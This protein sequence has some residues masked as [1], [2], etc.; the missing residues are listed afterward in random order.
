MLDKAS[1]YRGGNQC[2]FV[3]EGEKLSFELKE[4]VTQVPAEIT[5]LKR[6]SE[7]SWPT[8]EYTPTGLLEFSIEGMY[9]CGFQSCWKDT[10]KEKLEDRL[11]SIVQGFGQAFEYNKLKTIKRKAEEL[12][13]ERRVKRSQELLRLKKIEEAR[14]NH[15][16]ELTQAFEQAASIRNLILTFKESGST[17]E[18]FDKWLDWAAK[19]ANEI[20]P[21]DKQAEILSRYHQIEAEE[22]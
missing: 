12:E 1:G 5:N 4:P 9:W 20:D 8:R 22:F 13:W 10:T 3:F 14:R 16:F 17:E 6:K 11:I 15:L 2:V 19:I 7:Y 21:V 18:G